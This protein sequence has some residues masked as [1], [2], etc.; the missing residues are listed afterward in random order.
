MWYNGG[1]ARTDN[2]RNVVI[3]VTK[4]YDDATWRGRGVEVQNDG[5]LAL[6]T[7]KTSTVSKDDLLNQLVQPIT[8]GGT[9][10]ENSALYSTDDVHQIVYVPEHTVD[11][12][13][14]A[15]QYFPGTP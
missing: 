14:V 6:G 4:A 15:A 9:T 10:P 3:I 13:P 12:L 1:M 7:A 8:P 11:T 5:T 2:K